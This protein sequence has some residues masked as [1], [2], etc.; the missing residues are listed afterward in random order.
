MTTDQSVCA[1]PKKTF[2]SPA[3]SM[4]QGAGNLYKHVGIKLQLTRTKRKDKEVVEHSIAYPK[5]DKVDDEEVYVK[6]IQD[7][8]KAGKSLVSAMYYLLKRDFSTVERYHS[9]DEYEDRFEATKP[10]LDNLTLDDLYNDS[11]IVG[12]L[13]SDDH[14]LRPLPTSGFTRAFRALT[15]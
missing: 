8:I 11:K 7:S 4:V 9:C 5:D 6:E 14:K 10:V 13:F 12:K 2:L 3:L 15:V 1:V